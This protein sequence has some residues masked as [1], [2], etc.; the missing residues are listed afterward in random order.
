ME[1]QA[2]RA[3]ITEQ[4][5]N[6]IA[7]REAQAA[8]APVSDL[9]IRFTPA[10]VE[11]SGSYRQFVTLPFQ[12][13]WQVGVRQGKIIANLADVKVSGF[14]AA[15]FRGVMLGAVCSA[16]NAGDALVVRE[17]SLELNLERL[18]AL[19]GFPATLNLTGVRIQQGSLLIE[20]GPTSSN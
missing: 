18:L 15:M 19:H 5:I 20:A 14:G 11:V 6:D 7:R 12:T 4:E 8:G 3:I 17:D 9:A 10:G 16:L 2:L 13:L 1:I